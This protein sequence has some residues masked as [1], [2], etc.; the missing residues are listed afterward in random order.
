MRIQSGSFFSVTTATDQA[1]N[2]IGAQRAASIGNPYPA[3]QS[4]ASWLNT[5][6]FAQPALGTFGMSPN[7]ILGPG[8]FDI[9][10]S[11]VRNVRVREK[12]TIQLRAEAFNILNHVR[13]NNPNAS[14][15]TLSTFGKVTTFAD[16]RIMQFAFKYVF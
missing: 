4:F 11:L 15:S 12:Q 9:D 5:S 7:N 6:S 3:Q 1:L 13:P 14:I 16:P 10:A 8:T 2:S